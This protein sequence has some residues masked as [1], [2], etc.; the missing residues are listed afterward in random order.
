MRLPPHRAPVLV[1]V[2]RQSQRRI[3]L[4]SWVEC[5]V[6][7]AQG[8]HGVCDFL[9]S[10]SPLQ[11]TIQAPVVAV[12]EAKNENMKA[13]IAQCTAE[14]LAAQKFNTLRGRGGRVA[15]TIC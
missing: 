6:D 5:T 7:V 1:E 15:A 4:F 9:L 8:L 11:L 2:R 14:M 12:V 3:S 10:L 13:G